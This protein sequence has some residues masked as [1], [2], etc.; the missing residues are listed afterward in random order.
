MKL[1]GSYAVKIPAIFLCFLSFVAVVCLAV[2]LLFTLIS[3]LYTSPLQTVKEQT[4]ANYLDQHND[5]VAFCLVSRDSALRLQDLIDRYTYENYEFALYG[6]AGELLADTRGAGA[7]F[8][9]AEEAYDIGEN[10]MMRVP[11]TSGQEGVIRVYGQIPSP[12]SQEDDLYHTF[13]LLTAADRYRYAVPVLFFVA[14]T[15]HLA[16]FSYLMLAAG[17]RRDTDAP[18]CCWADRIPFDLYAAFFL[19]LAA[20]QIFLLSR[21]SLAGWWSILT[22]AVLL[23]VNQPLALAFCMSFATRAKTGTLLRNTLIARLFLVIF[24]AL[25]AVPVIPKTVIC[26]AVLFFYSVGVMVCGFFDGQLAAIL[27]TVGWAVTAVAVVSYAVA[28][29]KLKTGAEKIASGDLQFQISTLMLTGDL[30]RHAE[31]LNHIGQGLSR[32]VEQRLKSERFKT[33]LITNVSHDL[34]TPLTSIVSYIDLLG[35]EPMESERARGYIQ[36]LDRQARRLKK[37]T[38]DLVEASKAQTGNLRVE[39]VPCELCEL[40]SQAVG[41]YQ[42]KLDEAGLTAITTVPETPVKI[43][44]DG[45]HLW[46]IFDNLL[47]NI[48]KYSQSGTR[49]YLNL[50]VLDGMAY[51]I[52]RNT[53][54][55]P[56]TAS[57]EELTERFVRGDPSRHTEGSGLGLSIAR[58]LVELQKGKMDVTVD[59]D[60]FKVT[61]TF[62]TID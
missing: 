48:C 27:F 61:L 45:R 31:T 26:L 24:R 53:S 6:T 9:E 28:L 30:R 13:R 46:R 15:L 4:A 11:L 32:E 59:G 1:R 5:E 54:R 58:S 10:T 38:E 51:V 8:A 57:G 56:L 17:Y 43:L 3:G 21:V 50:R 12:L 16:L 36:V 7:T 49:V 60:L 41:E 40:F 37:L 20:G 62:Q 19:C 47:N 22:P 23:A 33:E 44:A 35:R 18:R 42:E 14:L 34:K 29:K 55:Y 25:R 2:C 39:A 52:F